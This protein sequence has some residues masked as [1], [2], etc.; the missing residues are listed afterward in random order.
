MF[1]VTPSRPTNYSGYGFAIQPYYSEELNLKFLQDIIK[2]FNNDQWEILWK[3]KVR[4]Q[5]RDSRIER[6]AG[7]IRLKSIRRRKSVRYIS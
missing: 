7:T 4:I 3:R 5:M 1:D 6:I 2:V